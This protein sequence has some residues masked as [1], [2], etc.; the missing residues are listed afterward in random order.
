MKLVFLGPPGVGK[1]TQ[2]DLLASDL[3]VPHYSTGDI[4]RKILKKS[5]PLSDKLEKYVHSGKL[6]PDE[7]VFETVKKVL[8][9]GTN[10]N[11][12]LLDGFPRNKSQAELLDD[13][14]E[15]RDEE[16][17]YAVY[18]Y[19]E[20]ET[21]ITRLSNRRVCSNCGAIYNLLNNPP[22]REGVCDKCGGKLIQREDDKIPTIKK[23]ISI[24]KRDVGPLK[25][26]YENS[27]V[28]ME[29]SA[30]SGLEKTAQKI[31]ERLKVGKKGSHKS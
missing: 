7:V 9:N 29:I 14:L 1:G 13:F 6:V 30:E 21:L 28:L 11:G 19:A 2:A 3:N 15:K 20:P 10:G 23:R 4:F 18:L 12:W 25:D 24:F 5:S 22:E 16:L 17:D 8:R 31:K 26:Y 27:G